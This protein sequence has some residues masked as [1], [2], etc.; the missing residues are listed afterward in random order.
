MLIYIMTD[1][2]SLKS[3]DFPEPRGTEVVV[4]RTIRMTI[5][6]PLRMSPLAE[7]RNKHFIVLQYGIS[8]AFSLLSLFAATRGASWTLDTLDFGTE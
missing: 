5:V 6:Q 1:L 7:A 8:L 4:S 3:L 2:A